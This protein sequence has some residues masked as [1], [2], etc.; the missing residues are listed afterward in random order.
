[1]VASSGAGVIAVPS[2]RAAFS[3]RPTCG[4]PANPCPKRSHRRQPSQRGW[5][6][7][8]RNKV[9]GTD[10]LAIDCHKVAGTGQ[11]SGW[12]RSI[13]GW[14]RSIHRSIPVDRGWHRSIVGGTDRSS[15]R[16]SWVAPIDRS[17]PIWVAPIDPWVVPIDPSVDPGRSWVAPVDHPDRSWVAPIDRGWHRS[18]RSSVGGTDRSIP[19]DWLSTV[20]KWLA[21]VDRSIPV[22]RG[23][24]RSIPR[25]IPIDQI[26]HHPGSI[27]E[28]SAPVCTPASAVRGSR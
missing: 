4:L 14:H 8:I 23:W 22:D 20:T 25:S 1:M 24:H 2:G 13:R 10:R 17:I 21:P 9:A 5:H 18:I 28:R 19:I 27:P 3:S 26:D 6:R 15:I 16:S 12:H 7:S 11:S